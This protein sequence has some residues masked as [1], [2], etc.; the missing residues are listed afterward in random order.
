[1]SNAV[2]PYQNR[3][4]KLHW[5]SNKQLPIGKNQGC[6]SQ[7][8]GCNKILQPDEVVGGL[9]LASS[10]IVKQVHRLMQPCVLL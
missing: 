8:Q 3:K 6:D 2:Y 10:H 7:K 1:M 4:H 9:L 5:K